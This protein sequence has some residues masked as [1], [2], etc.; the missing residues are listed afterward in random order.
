[1]AVTNTYYFGLSDIKI[2]SWIGVN[3]WGPAADIPAASQITLEV[4]TINGQLEGDNSIVDVH[5]QIIAG[6]ARIRFGF[7][8]LSYLSILTGATHLQ[9]S[10]RDSET[11]SAGDNMPYFGLCAKI[12]GTG[13]AGDAHLFIPKGKLTEGFQLAMQYGQYWTPEVTIMAVDGG[14]PFGVMRIIRHETAADVTI[15]PA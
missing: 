2:A 1:M 15:P 5:A 10:D 8:D 4:Q 9:S 3:N 11:F 6:T 13:T 12:P 7:N 14:S